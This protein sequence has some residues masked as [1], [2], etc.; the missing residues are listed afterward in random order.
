MRNKEAA[1][2]ILIKSVGKLKYMQWK[3]KIYTAENK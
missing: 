1:Q 2:N 3:I